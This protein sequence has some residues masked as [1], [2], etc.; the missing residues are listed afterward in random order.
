MPQTRACRSGQ[1]LV[2]KI[3]QRH[4]VEG[5]SIGGVK[6]GDYVSMRPWT[7]M[8]HDNSHAVIRKFDGLGATHLYDPSKIVFALDHDIQNDSEANKAR[9][10]EIE[11]FAKHKGVDFYPA[12][13]GIGHQVIVPDPNPKVL[14][15]R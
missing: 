15:T 10:A 6:P 9:Y 2:Q 13:R 7:T 3:L 5:S 14:G 11:L 12:G 1:S 4:L 8:T